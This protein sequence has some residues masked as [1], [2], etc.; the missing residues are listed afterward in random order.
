MIENTVRVV[1]AITITH[2]DSLRDDQLEEIALNAVHIRPVE[3]FI[4]NTY[5]HVQDYNKEIGY[6]DL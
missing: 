5:Y 2:N 6:Y 4:G 3:G 1:V